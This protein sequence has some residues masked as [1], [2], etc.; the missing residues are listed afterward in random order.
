[1]PRLKSTNVRTEK[2]KIIVPLYNGLQIKQAGHTLNCSDPEPLSSSN[3]T[4]QL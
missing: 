1:M 3:N 2:I 4:A